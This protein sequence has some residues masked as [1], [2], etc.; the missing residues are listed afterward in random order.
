VQPIVMYVTW[1]AVNTAPRTCC[2]CTDTLSVPPPVMT[3]S[4]SMRRCRSRSSSSAMLR[5]TCTA[6]SWAP[7]AGVAASCSIQARADMQRSLFMC[8]S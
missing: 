2:N 8:P 6:D 5:S 7:T 3:D 1:Y 4:S